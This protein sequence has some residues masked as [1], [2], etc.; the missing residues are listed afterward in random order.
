MPHGISHNYVN[1]LYDKIKIIDLSADFRLDSEKLYS[2]NYNNDHACP[3]LL[4]QFIYGLPEINK[5]VLNTNFDVAVPGCYPTSVLIPLIPL[6]EKNLIK[7]LF[8]F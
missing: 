6:L 3:E 4:N 7:H 8:V 2:K 5:D 1:K